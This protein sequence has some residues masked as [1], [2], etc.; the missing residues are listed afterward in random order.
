[1]LTFSNCADTSSGFLHGLDG[2]TITKQIIKELDGSVV[3]TETEVL[4]NNV[5]NVFYQVGSTV[6]ESIDTGIYKVIISYEKDGFKQLF[7]S[8]R[9]I[10][11]EA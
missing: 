7:A 10:I 2:A 4:T 9:Y 6:T 1:M 3:D 5:E 8:C 11:E